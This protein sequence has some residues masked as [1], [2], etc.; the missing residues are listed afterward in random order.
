MERQTFD[1]DALSRLTGV[2]FTSGNHV[3]SY[4]ANGNRTTH[5]WGGA[6]DSYSVASTGKRLNSLSATGT[7]AR[8]YTH[9]AA[10]H[11]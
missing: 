9:D 1:Y 6:L 2:T 7:R 4:D 11:L 8:S 5:T 10:G 3:I